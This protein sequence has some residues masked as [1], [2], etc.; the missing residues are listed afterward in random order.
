MSSGWADP[1]DSSIGE[2]RTHNSK[3]TL[4]RTS[5]PLDQSTF[6]ETTSPNNYL[7]N[8]FNDRLKQ[9]QKF[10]AP[11]FWRPSAKVLVAHAQNQACTQCYIQ[12]S[13]F[14]INFF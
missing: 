6:H 8:I 10:E 11:N 5:G 2:V 1:F 12:I 14:L 7:T 9:K 3:N 13:F 4:G